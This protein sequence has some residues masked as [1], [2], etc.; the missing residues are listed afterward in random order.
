MGA[1]EETL[2]LLKN[3]RLT[4]GQIAQRRGVSLGT[5]LGYLEQM[6]GRGWLRRSEL[7]FSVPHEVHTALR[8]VLVAGRSTSLDAVC[9]RLAKRGH[10]FKRD[11]V[12]VALRYRDAK[13][14]MGDMYEEIRLIESGLH[15]A[16]RQ[17]L[18]YRFGPAEAGWWRRGVPEA[19]RVRCQARRESEVDTDPAEP[20]AYSTM[21]EL[22]EIIDKN[23]RDFG[24]HMVGLSNWTKKDF[25]TK[26]QRLNRIRNLVMH[27][28][29]AWQPSEADF[30][31]V[32]ELQVTL[33]RDLQALPRNPNRA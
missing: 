15:R 33:S 9:S 19:I 17:V 23:W 27:P 20:F 2:D 6:V 18:T 3:D 29:R 5:V 25:N 14:A 8:D 4:P 13:F 11:D 21:L 16:V 30:A 28:V 10:R 22:A 12:E 31:F 32:S 7:R 26:M 1:R 24:E